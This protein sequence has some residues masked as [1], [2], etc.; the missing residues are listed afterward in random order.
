MTTMLKNLTVS[1]SPHIRDNVSTRRLMGDVIIA[2]M[3]AAIA[4]IWFFGVRSLI[5]M[6]VS[7]V[8]AVA[9]EAYYQK[10]SKQSVTVSDLS[11]VVTGLLLAFNLPAGVPWWLA[12]IGSILAIVLVKQLFGGLGQNFM[13]PALAAR[14]I[15]FISWMAIMSSYPTPTPGHFLT[16]LVP[17]AADVISKSTPLMTARKAADGAYSLV[18]STGISLWQMFAGEVP[19]VL[20]ETSKLALLL[21][22]VYMLY[23]R[24]VSWRIPA[25]FIGAVFLCYLVKEGTQVNTYAQAM[26]GNMSAAWGTALSNTVFQVLSGSVFLGAIFMATDYSTSPMTD[27]GKIIMGLGCG[28][29]LFVIRAFSS[30]PEGC[31]F[32]ILFMNVA[33]PLID[34]LTMPKSFGEVKQ[35]A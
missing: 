34:R 22:L 17:D 21:G 16:G 14:V 30:Y 19:G 32:A 24:V 1:S 31:S 7:V 10:K 13:N 6:A 15:L 33:T 11:A 26:S 4:S 9:A 3:P 28:I 5:L 12:A 29:L 2:L 23:R 20:G 27:T 8:S 18:S 35:H 25:A